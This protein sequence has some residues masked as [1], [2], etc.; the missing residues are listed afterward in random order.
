MVSLGK[1]KINLK[2]IFAL[3]SPALDFCYEVLLRNK[4]K[5]NICSCPAGR[6]SRRFVNWWKRETENR[7]LTTENNLLYIAKSL[8]LHESLIIFVGPLNLPELTGEMST[9]T[10]DLV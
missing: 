4:F 10:V 9:I 3:N 1:K 2:V 8:G 5:E 7:T 6:F